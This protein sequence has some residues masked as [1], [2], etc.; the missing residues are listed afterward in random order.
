LSV[1]VSDA[2]RAGLSGRC[3]NCG[4]GKL[5]AGYLK[6]APRC[7][8]CGADF[9][10]A[11]T[12]DGAS[13]FVMFLVGAIVV[14]LA[15]I[16]QFSAHAPTWATMAITILAAIGLSLGFLRPFKAILFTLQ[17]T[18]KAEEGKLGE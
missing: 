16:L 7:A 1:R 17:W 3:P 15:F 8:A 6:L 14:P 11:D 18:H 9:S 5:F 4:K 2:I 13:V 12:G 10:M